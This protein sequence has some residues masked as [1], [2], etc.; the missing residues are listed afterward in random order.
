MSIAHSL[1]MRPSLYLSHLMLLVLFLAGGWSPNQIYA[2]SLESKAYAMELSA[3]V[4]RTPAGVNIS[5]PQNAQNS[6]S[7]IQVYRRTNETD[8]WGT[9]I[10][11]LAATATSY[12]DT[13][14]SIGIVYEYWIQQGSAKGYIVSGI[15]VPLVENRGKVILLVDNTYVANLSV[16]LARL[17]QDLTGDGWT[18]VRRDVARNETVPNVKATVKAVYDADPTNVKALFIFGH[19]PVPYSGQIAPDGHS[20][21]VGA[22]PADVFYGDMDGVWTDATINATTA[23]RA[24]NR[25]VPGDGKYDQ[26]AIPSDV[27]LQVGRVDLANMPAFA[28]RTELDLLRQYL[29][30]DHNFRLG[31]LPLERRGLVDDNFGAFGGEAFGSSGWRNFSTFFGASNVE[32]RKFFTTL[33]TNGYLW[34]YGCGGGWYQGAGGV[35]STNDFAAT[36]TKAVFTLLFG[37]YFGDWDVG[38]S[39][40][41]APL[42]TTTYGLT[43]AWAGRPHWT[44][45]QMALGKNIGYSARLTQNDNYG[46]QSNY[47][48]RFVHIALMGDPTLRMHPVLPPTALTAAR[49]GANISLSWT[50][51]PDANQ[52]Y[53]VYRSGSATGPFT[54]LTASPITATSFTDPNAAA[55]NYTYEIR[56]VKL[57]TSGSGTYFNSSQGAFKNTRTKKQFDFDGDGRDDLSVFRPANNTWYLQLSNG[58]FF[59]NPFGQSGDKLAPA[60]YDGDGKADIAVFRNGIW[61]VLQ[62]SNNQVRIQQFGQAGDVPLPADYDGDGRADITVWRPSDGTW[63]RINSSNN[64]FTAA[65]FGVST[66]KPVP[67][68]YDGDGKTDIAVYRN[69]T[70]YLQQSTS[71]F[72]AVQWGAATDQPT[73]ADFDGDGKADLAIYRP[74]AGEWYIFQSS[75]NQL[76]YSRWGASGDIATPA[77]YDGDGKADVAVFRPSNG[78]WYLQRS[79]AGVGIFQFG[80][81]GDNPL[82]SAFLP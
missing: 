31:L 9:P 7:S 2:Q 62:S 56:A 50:A 39:F 60:D 25:N 80:T 43:S 40:L 18:V 77:D 46:Y 8:A 53:L 30:K 19:V 64:Q 5:W 14:V 59:S 81:S 76:R 28:P 33:S 21:H 37:S 35:G 63:Y 10:S 74:S 36:D 38:D 13:N 41:R 65:A 1:A 61:Y 4:Q 32:A 52:G 24:E 72:R 54:K 70:W 16:E 12:A 23:S 58:G 71:G 75:N 3:T 82:P 11:T 47:G 6:A 17:E 48:S 67:A 22:W 51:S 20:D 26:S 69:G 78:T 15:E 73:A 66:D 29:N 34:G 68:D 79:T 49:N 57:E 27:E 44:L 42:A 55:G 45:H